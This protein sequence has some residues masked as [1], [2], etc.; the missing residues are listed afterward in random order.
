ML[1]KRQFLIKE[2]VGLLKLADTYD[3]FDPQNGQ[4][5]GIAKEVG[6]A[7]MKVLR[8]FINKRLLP[9]RVDISERDG[10]PTL[11]SIERGF[12]LLR[13]AVLVKNAQGQQIGQFKSK[14]LSLGGGFF[15][16]NPAG[17]QVA[18]VKGDWKGWNFSFIGQGGKEIGTVTKKWAGIGKELFSSA[19]NYMINIS[20]TQASSPDAAALLIAAG[21][22]IDIVF[23]EK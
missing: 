13:A 11:F 19:D 4:Q 9:T 15:V 3:I 23:K 8:L 2:R 22:A 5:I 7:L 18:D 10:G 1:N 17:Q 21:L 14:F 20:D 16:L 6:S 12:T